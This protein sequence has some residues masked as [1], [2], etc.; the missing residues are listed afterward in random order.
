MSGSRRA[1]QFQPTQFDINPVGV[2]NDAGDYAC[3]LRG[4]S[5]HLGKRVG[6]ALI[7]LR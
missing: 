4:G 1:Q 2:D 5:Q 6:T 3:Q 7:N